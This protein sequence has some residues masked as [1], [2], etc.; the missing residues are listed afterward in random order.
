[1]GLISKGAGMDY[2]D[3]HGV[4]LWAMCCDGWCAGSAEQS[5][6]GGLDLQEMSLGR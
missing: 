6:L 1:M 4:T 3:A 5:G 2:C